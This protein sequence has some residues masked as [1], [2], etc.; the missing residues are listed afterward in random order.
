MAEIKYSPKA[1][2]DLSDIKGYIESEFSS[3]ELAERILKEITNRVRQLSMF[4]MSGQNLSTIIDVQTD[5]YF[6]LCKKNY[7]FYRI[8]N[9]EVRI[10]R[11]L[12]EKKDYM[13]VLFGISNVVA[14]DENVD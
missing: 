6:L 7:V 1:L 10:I 2:A 8:E 14:G 9:N 4:P 3:K 11:I 12:S 13:K 5:Y